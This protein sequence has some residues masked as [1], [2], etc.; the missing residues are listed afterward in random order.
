[1]KGQIVFDRSGGLHGL[2]FQGGADIRQRTGCK[3]QR[4]GVVSLPALVFGAQVEASRVLQIWGQYNSL[5]T[6]FSRQLNTQVPGI[7]GDKSEFQLLL[8][9]AFLRESIDAVNGISEAA[10]VADL[11]PGQGG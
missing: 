7:E 4:L 1:V 5:I 3:G 11:V 9:Q 2:Y 10:C 6:S 8:K